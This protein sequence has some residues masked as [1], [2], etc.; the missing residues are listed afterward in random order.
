MAIRLTRN[1]HDAED[2]VA[3]TVTKAW[4]SLHLLKDE[5]QFRPL[6]ICILR[7]LYISQYRKKKKSRPDS[8]SYDA[9]AEG[10]NDGEVAALL[11]EQPNEFLSC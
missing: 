8:S 3:E 11:V 9:I 4:K 10:C 1:S 6:I 2:L 5:E 7:N